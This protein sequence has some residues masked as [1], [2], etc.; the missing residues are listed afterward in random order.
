MTSRDH[1]AQVTSRPATAS[2]GTSRVVQDVAG[3]SH[4]RP[5]TMLLTRA[6]CRAAPSCRRARQVTNPMWVSCEG[7]CRRW[8]VTS[9][10]GRDAPPAAS[11][12]QDLLLVRIEL[13]ELV[14][15]GWQSEPPSLHPASR[16]LAPS[17]PAD[18]TMPRVVN[19]PLPAEPCPG[20]CGVVT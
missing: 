14:A 16:R 11:I 3:F 2:S 7:E 20:R 19:A 15:D 5:V 18:I 12:R 9:F 1:R 10:I 6:A 8:M 13:A 4:Q 17:A